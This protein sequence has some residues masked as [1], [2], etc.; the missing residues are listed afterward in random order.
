VVVSGGR[1]VRG[2][3]QFSLIEELARV[4]GGAVGA[5]RAVVD[6]KWRP[7][8]EQVGKSGRT[9]SPELYLAVGISGAVHHIMGMDTARVIVAVN[10]DPKALIFNHADYGIVDDLF[11]VIPALVEEIGRQQTGGESRGAE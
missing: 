9:V 1:G 3:E 8:E 2:P 10:N 4:L 7:A 6:G 5:S 11:Q